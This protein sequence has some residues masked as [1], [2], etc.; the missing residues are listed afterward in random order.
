MFKGE[1]RAQCA[2][3]TVYEHRVVIV[4]VR[5]MQVE[6]VSSGDPWKYFGFDLNEM[7]GLW[8]M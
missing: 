4:R 1:Q 8:M 2:C 6:C 5:E 7:R 3:G